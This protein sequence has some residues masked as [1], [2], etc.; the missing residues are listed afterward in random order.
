VPDPS[1]ERRHRP[2]PDAD[3][4]EAWHF[5]FAAANGVAG[6]ARLTLLPNRHRA[7][8][9]S[10]L[11]RP[12]QPVVVLVDDEVPLPPPH[13]LE[14]RTAGLWA[15]VHCETPFEHWT[16]GLEGFAL[17]FENPADIASGRGDRT[18]LGFD[19]E[20]EATSPPEADSDAQ[21]CVVHGEILVGDDAIAV[22]G[23]GHRRHSWGAASSH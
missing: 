7:E 8:W 5:E 3:W 13:L 23:A 12:G 11:L 17:A 6:H 10:E 16:V 22:E 15:A 9:S 21:A 18:A 1:R 4:A 20:W 2:G 19:L 14:I